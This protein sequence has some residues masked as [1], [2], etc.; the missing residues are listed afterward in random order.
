M[1][2]EDRRDLVVGVQRKKLG[3]QLVVGIEAHTMRFVGQ[4]DL[5]E[6]DR[7]LD[8]VGGRQG[9]ELNPLGVLGR[10]FPG[11]GERRQIGH[12]KDPR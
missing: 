8:A 6:H 9:V 2:V 5:F 1:G 3:R 11:D 10:P 7:H 12:G 4:T